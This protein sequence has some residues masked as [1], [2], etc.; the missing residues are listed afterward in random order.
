MA[1]RDA[2]E[3]VLVVGRVRTAG[4]EAVVGEVLDVLVERHDVDVLQADVDAHARLAVPEEVGL[5]SDVGHV[6]GRLE[7]SSAVQVLDEHVRRRLH[8]Q[9][10]RRTAP[11]NRV[12]TSG[13]ATL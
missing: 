10:C 9:S 4:D 5:L 8:A 1:S 2:V 12:T 6:V 13:L 7:A 3:P 11:R